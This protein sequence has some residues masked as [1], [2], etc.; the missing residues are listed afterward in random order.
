MHVACAHTQCGVADCTFLAKGMYLY[1]ASA[2]AA[3]EQKWITLHARSHT[4]S[5][6][7]RAS[8]HTTWNQDVQR[9]MK[10]AM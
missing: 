9:T 3:K 8:K 10:N 7:N 2:K 4:L 5:E 1:P 6:V